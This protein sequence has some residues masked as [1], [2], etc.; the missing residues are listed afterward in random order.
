MNQME[1]GVGV[2]SGNRAGLHRP[3]ISS[4]PVVEIGSI[5]GGRVWL[6]RGRLA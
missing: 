4:A 3:D 1:I 6:G 2:D 5:L